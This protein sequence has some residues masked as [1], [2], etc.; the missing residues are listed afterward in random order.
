MGPSLISLIDFID[1]SDFI[2]FLDF[3][4][5]LDFID[6][7]FRNSLGTYYLVP[8]TMCPWAHGPGPLVAFAVRGG[9]LSSRRQRGLRKDNLQQLVL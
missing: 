4:G 8:W 9:C 3:L 7:D 5:F 6:L 2:N 1:F